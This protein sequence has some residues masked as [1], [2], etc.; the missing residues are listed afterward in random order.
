MTITKI[1]RR[2]VLK[3]LLDEMRGQGK[4]IVFTNGCFDILHVG[5]LR[6][7]QEARSL[8]DCLVVGVNTDESVRQIKGPDRPLV[9]EFDRAEL[10]TG[11]KCVDYVTLFC[12]ETPCSLIDELRPDIH[13]KGGDYR[14]DDLPE[15]EIVKSYGGEVRILP[16]VEG[17]STTNLVK[18]MHSAMPGREGQCRPDVAGRAAVGIIPARLAATRLPNKPLLDIAG[19]PMIQ[20]V[21]EHASEA[22]SLT[23]VLVATPDEEIFRAVEAFGGKAVI[24]SAEHLSGTDRLAEAAQSP[25]CPDADV[26]VNIQGDEPLLDP[27][28]IDLLAEAILADPTVPMASLM[29]P[30]QND[31]ADDPAVVKV[32]TDPRGFALYFS[33]ARIPYPRQPAESWKHIGVYAYT[34]DFLLEFPMLCPTPLEQAESLE[35]LRALENGYPIRM[36][37]TDFAPTS[38]DTP[39]DLEKVRAAL[40]QAA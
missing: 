22:R 25:A 2:S 6:Y 36:V 35:Q 18:R 21:Y 7:L 37:A 31:E 11:L 20:W 26:I 32:V 3:G 13:A 9:S 8:G 10:L 15:A 1:V 39:D 40:E 29:C 24:T 17:K 5:H 28:A 30:L 27:A 33:R 19:K 23:E 34:R 4:R 16:E 14:A 12:E 38:V